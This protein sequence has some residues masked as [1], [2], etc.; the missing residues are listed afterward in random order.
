MIRLVK[1]GNVIYENIE[2]YVTESKFDETGFPKFD[3][4]GSP[5]DF[6]VVLNPILPSDLETAKQIMKDTVDWFTTQ[7]IK[8]KFDELQE[9][10]A[11]IISEKQV[12]EGK[13]YTA[14]LDPET[15]RNEVIA[16]VSGAK[17]KDEVINQLNI[18]DNLVPSF[19]R[20]IEIGKLLYWK[21]LVWDEEAKIEA[22]ID[23][24][25]TI[26]EVYGFD[27]VSVCEQRYGVI[28]L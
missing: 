8:R 2:L 24:L 16:V 23:M 7:Y 17:T 28:V 12:L 3:E 1:I 10:L 4:T 22:E 11:D 6:R 26:E 9:D 13:F 5:V 25:Q 27:V 18:P 20:A 21:E 14:G 15:V 19:D